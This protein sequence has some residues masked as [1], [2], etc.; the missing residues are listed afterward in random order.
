M[1]IFDRIEKVTTGS[2]GNGYLAAGLHTLKIVECKE[3][4]GGYRGD[5][6]VAVFE[7]VDSTRPVSCH[8]AHPVAMI[9]AAASSKNDYDDEGGHRK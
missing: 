8:D 6:F 7:V 4:T 5:S 2:Q 3:I 9:F 1:G